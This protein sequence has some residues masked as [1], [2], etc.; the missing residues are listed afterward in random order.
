MIMWEDASPDEQEYCSK[1]L[2]HRRHVTEKGKYSDPNSGPI[3]AP[4]HARPEL[5][6]AVECACCRINDL[7]SRPD[8]PGQ[9]TTISRYT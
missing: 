3:N 4:Q 5:K 2:L 1:V 7:T 8:Q 6:E 9:Y